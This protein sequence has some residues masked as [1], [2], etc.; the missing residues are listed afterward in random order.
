MVSMAARRPVDGHILTAARR[1]MQG[2]LRPPSSRASSRTHDR[3]AGPEPRAPLVSRFRSS[4]T[5][6]ALCHATFRIKGTLATLYASSAPFEPEV[7]SPLAALLLHFQRIFDGLEG[8]ELDVV[9]LAL[10]LL[11]LADVD[12]LDDVARLRINRD[13]P[14]RAFPCHALHGVDQAIAVGLALGLLECLVDRV[15]AVVAAERDEVRAIAVRLLES[16]DV[17]LV[18]RRIVVRRIDAGGDHAQ[19]RIAHAGKVVVVDDVAG[20]DELDAGLVEAA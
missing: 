7:R 15:H 5:L 18:G 12:V 1:A 8:L 6:A 2:R 17:L 4:Q 9:K 19:H 16:G 13:L 20:A 14:A 10:H 11:D 3:R